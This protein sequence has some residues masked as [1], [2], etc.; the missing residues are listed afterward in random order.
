MNKIKT[1][2]N[3]LSKN[4]KIIYLSIS[5]LLSILVLSQFYSA[6]EAIGSAYYNLTN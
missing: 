1:K 2:Y 3:S 6:G 4:E 5:I